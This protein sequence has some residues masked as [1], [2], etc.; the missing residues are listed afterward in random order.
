MALRLITGPVNPVTLAEAKAQCRANDAEDDLIAI[1]MASAM[2]HIDGRNGVLG[3]AIATQTWELSYDAFPAGPIELPLPPLQSVTSI[4]YYDADG[5]LRTLDPTEYVVDTESDPGWV[6]PADSWPATY[7]TLNA[8]RIRFVAGYETTPAP[9]RAAMLLLTGELYAH[10]E[11]SV[12]AALTRNPAVERL[13]FPFKVL[14][15]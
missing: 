15:P 5:V 10:R 6:A 11:G 12:E 8:V 2:E 3:R 7:D 4:A 13:L 9:V 1:Y 14:R